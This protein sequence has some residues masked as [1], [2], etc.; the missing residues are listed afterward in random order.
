MKNGFIDATSWPVLAPWN[1]TFLVLAILATQVLVLILMG[2]PL[3]CA[4]GHID[5]RHA[6]ASGP[7]TSQHFADGYS[8]THV[9]HGLLFYFLLW[10]IFRKAPFAVVFVLAL[11]IEAGWEIIENTPVVIERYRQTALAAGYFG[12]SII[13]SVGDT[14]AMILGFVVARVAPFGL[15]MLVLLGL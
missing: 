9:A 2:Q 12:D 11:G 8:L 4:C 15:S 5:L 6:A 10:L 1:L 3:V 13:N 7:E 14:L